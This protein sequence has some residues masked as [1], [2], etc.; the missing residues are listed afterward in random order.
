MKDYPNI[1][2]IVFDT[3][4]KDV[5]PIYGGNAITPNLNEF[6]KDAV[7]FSNAITPASWTIPS[8]I[9]FFTGLYPREHGVHE[10]FNEI[11]ND[12]VHYE[13]LMKQ[14]F[15]SKTITEKLKDKG[16][17][18]IG[19]SANP[20]IAPD[21]GF[22]KGFDYFEYI[23]SRYLSS[24][25]INY[26]KKF[27]KNGKIN[28]K[29]VLEN[30]KE[31]PQL[32]KI[33]RKSRY[34]KKFYDYPSVKGANLTIDRL[35]N[36]SF[37]KPFFIFFN[38]MEPHEPYIKWELRPPYPYKQPLFIHDLAG[39]KIPG[40]IMNMIKKTYIENLNKLDFYFEKLIKYLKEVKEY[41][42]TMIIVTSDHGQALKE[43]NYYTHGLFL[44]N[45][46]IEIP[47]IVK[48][49]NSEKI[50]VKEGHQSLT[51]L[52]ELITN[53]SEGNIIDITRESV[54][55]ESFGFMYNLYDILKD[56]NKVE[57]M[58][59]MYGHPRKAIYKNNY[60]LVVS[61]LGGEI[62]EFTFKGKKLAPNENKNVLDDLIDE[63]EIF[64]GT[65]SFVVRKK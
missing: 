46:I 31:I 2:F 51:Y 16:Y 28:I 18:T 3:L 23:D 56:K 5:L 29:N 20:T 58:K 63:L 60:K 40:R 64:K 62:E 41:E 1:I 26:G 9:S 14:K 61:G 43:K 38:F 37:N 34:L 42:N 30:Y 53:V 48:F 50:I 19:I 8:H 35:D 13:S 6:R 55:S 27:F 33:Y 7:V 21:T 59:N 54:F 39:N 47:L 44:Y 4:R 24:S 25:E 36:I 45:E 12:F 15:D 57:K 11:K 65:D 49:P 32:Y 17:D 52:P 22:D 10:Y